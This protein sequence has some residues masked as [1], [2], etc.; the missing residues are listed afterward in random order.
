VTAISLTLGGGL[1]CG[2]RISTTPPTLVNGY[3]QTSLK[4]LKKCRDIQEGPS[5]EIDEAVQPSLCRHS[6]QG[7]QARH[8][9]LLGSLT[10]RDII[11]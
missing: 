6:L 5:A 4:A 10:E 9:G 11:R 7:A 8:V 2:D 3:E 1:L